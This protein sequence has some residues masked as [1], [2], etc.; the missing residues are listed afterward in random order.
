MPGQQEPDPE[1]ERRVHKIEKDVTAAVDETSSI[2]D[3]GDAD[4]EGDI[5]VEDQESSVATPWASKPTTAASKLKHKVRRTADK[6]MH[7]NGG[8]VPALAGVAVAVALGGAVW[9]LR[10]ARRRRL[11]KKGRVDT[12]HLMESCL[13]EPSDAAQSGQPTPPLLQRTFICASNF[14]IEDLSEENAVKQHGAE[15]G[16]GFQAAACIQQAVKAGATCLG[17]SR[18]HDMLLGVLDTELNEDADEGRIAGGPGAAVGLLV[19]SRVADFGLLLDHLTGARTVA[20]CCGLFGFRSTPGMVQLDG[21]QTVL[22][23]IDTLGW[24]T[25]DALLLQRVGAAYGLPG[26]TSK[27]DIST[28]IL[29]QDLF[30]MCGEQMRGTYVAAVHAARTFAGEEAHPVALTKFLGQAVPSLDALMGHLDIPYILG[31]AVVLRLLLACYKEVLGWRAK[32][33]EGGDH[34]LAAIGTA[35]STIQ[36]HEYLQRRPELKHNGGRAN[37]ADTESVADNE[38]L[39]VGREELAHAQ[40]VQREVSDALREALRGGNII[41]I[42]TMPGGPIPRTAETEEQEA[43]ETLTLQLTALA[44]MAGLPQAVIPVRWPNKAPMSI[45]I[46]GL[47]RKDMQLLDLAQRVAPY[48][49]DGMHQWLRDSKD[50]LQRHNKASPSEDVRAPSSSSQPSAAASA[51]ESSAEQ[52]KDSA[53]EAFRREDFAEAVK[54]YSRAIQACPKNPKYY[55][56]R[57]A[58]RLKLFHFS[59]AKDDC[60]SALKLELNVKAL[61]RRGMANLGLQEFADAQRDFLHVLQ[62][63][64]NNRQAK[65]ELETLKQMHNPTANGMDFTQ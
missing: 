19:R 41:M 40:K 63:E 32:E 60:D 49:E 44:T 65:E 56:N 10:K 4:G 25:R 42:P 54:G 53:N 26:G 3:I 11:K 22:G 21:V 14:E 50:L 37:G 48:V 52:F 36:R 46:L 13:L 64:P 45:S 15:A 47:P 18:G 28:F 43:F 16:T 23:L 55:N 59:L 1:T 12:E 30:A 27:G 57:A 29:A 17:R 34:I 9:M 35:A 20:A 61:L 8:V 38:D 39:S 33:G 58:A 5:G 31:Q 2:E 7:G 24:T 62:L 51:R 6:T